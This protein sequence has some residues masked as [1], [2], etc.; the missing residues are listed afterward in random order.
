MPKARSIYEQVLERQPAQAEAWR[1]LGLTASRMGQRKDAEHAFERY[2][3]LRPK[4]PDAARIR[5][6]LDKVR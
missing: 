3:K 6:Q 5:E 1:G 2:L 4:A